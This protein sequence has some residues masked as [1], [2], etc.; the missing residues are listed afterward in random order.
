MK[1]IQAWYTYKKGQTLVLELVCTKHEKRRKVFNL[2]HWRVHSVEKKCWGVYIS[3]TAESKGK[4]MRCRIFIWEIVWKKEESIVMFMQFR[5]AWCRNLSRMKRKG[6]CWEWR[7]IPSWKLAWP[8]QR[9]KF[10]DKTNCCFVER[11]IKVSV[12]LIGSLNYHA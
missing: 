3:V 6:K 11:V 9:M 4:G 12:I 2:I 7:K 8:F 1:W 10:R 5:K